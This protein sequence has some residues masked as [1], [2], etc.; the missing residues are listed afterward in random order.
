MESKHCGTKI[1]RC[2][3]LSLSILLCG[4][5]F[6]AQD[7]QT[8]PAL[9][10]FDKIAKIMEDSKL[11]YE[12]G[13]DENLPAQAIESSRGLSD[14]AYLQEGKDGSYTL[15][16]FTLSEEA[17]KKL[18][19]GEE[20]FQAKDYDLAL[21]LY[22][23]VRSLQ[24]EYDHV[25]TVIG[26]VHY[27]KGDYPKARDCYQKAIEHNFA[28]YQAHWFLADAYWQLGEKKA[29]IEQIT[30]AHLLNV[31]HAEIKKALLRYRDKSGRPWKEWRFSPRYVLSRDGDKVKVVSGKDWVAYAAVKA[32]WK[33]EPKYAASMVGPDYENRP[34]I[35]EE[36]KEALIAYLSQKEPMKEVRA[37][38]DG[39]YI[40]EF[41]YYEQLAPKASTA[42]VLFPRESFNRII[43]YIDKY[44]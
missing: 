21:K 42:M 33:Y 37:I 4:S 34:I 28:D 18:K 14:Q 2:I 39:G 17:T 6:F 41:I 44:H 12:L 43:E 40:S 36:E 20:A 13:V 5:N 22:D 27:M 15:T 29:A 1:F 30:A 7:V 24:P 16:H 32:V 31:N 19:Q 26:D 25:F 23:E 10:T 35:M 9:H 3:C 38:L 11:V 8:K